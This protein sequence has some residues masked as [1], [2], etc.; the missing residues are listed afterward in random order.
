[1]SLLSRK[2]FRLSASGREQKL[3]AGRVDGTLLRSAFDR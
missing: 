3:R 1:M 2:E